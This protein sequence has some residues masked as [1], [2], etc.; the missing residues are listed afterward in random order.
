MGPRNKRE[1][2][3]TLDCPK[4]GRR[5]VLTEDDAAF[6]FPRFLCLSCGNRLA[7]PLSTDEFLELVRNPDRDRRLQVD[8]TG[9]RPTA[10]V[11]P[12]PRGPGDSG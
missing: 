3:L 1:V 6:F 10:P 8:G 9:P 12:A 4:C 2:T 7:I 5:N 11:K